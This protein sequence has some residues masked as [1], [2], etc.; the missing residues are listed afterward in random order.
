MPT[1]A[2]IRQEAANRFGGNTT[3]TTTS[4]GTTTTFVCSTLADSGESTDRWDGAW[5]QMT[6]GTAGNIGAIRRIVSGV[7]GSGTFTVGYAFTS[8]TASGDGF[9][10][11][12]HLSPTDWNNAINRALRRRMRERRETITPVLNQ[13]HYSLASYTDI[14]EPGQVVDLYFRD[15][16]TAAET[17]YRQVPPYQWEVLEDDDGLTLYLD[18]PVGPGSNS[19]FYI[20]MSYVG[21]YA[22]ISTDSTTTTCPLDWIVPATILAALEMYAPQLEQRAFGR[23]TER[24]Q[25]YALEVLRMDQKYG[26]KRTRRL[27]YVRFA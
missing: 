8:A 13:T 18:P 20:I 9:E 23:V 19:D 3:G 10:L 21:P 16:P 6:S 17:T 4:S 11:N 25:E 2:A 12:E 5:V 14:T 27:P 7:A 24:K 1:R 26:P 15:G 22:E